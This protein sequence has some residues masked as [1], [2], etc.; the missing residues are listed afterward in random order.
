MSDKPVD[1]MS[2]DELREEL[3]EI[4]TLI[5]D[6]DQGDEWNEAL[7]NRHYLVDQELS[8]REDG[9]SWKEDIYGEDTGASDGC[10][11]CGSTS[12][13]SLDNRS[14]QGVV[15]CSVCGYEIA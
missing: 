1:Q 13:V 6:P 15:V 8:N 12:F 5:S 7:Q 9:Y 4:E 10:P 14:G 3:E 11:K 2:D